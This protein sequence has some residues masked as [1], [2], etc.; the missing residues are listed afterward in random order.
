MSTAQQTTTELSSQEL[1]NEEI[2]LTSANLTLY[3]SPWGA[4]IRGLVADKVTHLVT[5]YQGAG[6]TGGEGDVLIPFPGRVS[7]G[8]YN[9]E[10]VDYQM[11]RNDSDGPN[12]IHGFVRMKPWKTIDHTESSATFAI[13]LSATEAPGYP[14][15]LHIEVSYEVN[16]FGFDTRYKIT[17]VGETNAPVAAGFHPYFSLGFSSIDDTML[18]VPF[19]SFLVFDDGLLPTGAVERVS[20]SIYNFKEERIIADTKFNTCFLDPIRDDAGYVAI[21]LRSADAGRSLQV[22]LGPEINYVVLYSGD[23]LPETHRRKA[24]A[25]EPMSCGSDA[26]NHPEWGLV[27]LKSGE[28][29]TGHWG[30]RYKSTL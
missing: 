1:R 7:G 11:N 29:L 22:I 27:A 6:K 3:V 30:V 5:R 26:F 23:P 19:D 4:S 21:N 15:P 28:T 18:T 9:F 17:N 12:A 2:A 14:F 24:L 20:R 8:K 16:A 13:D 25:I 10:G